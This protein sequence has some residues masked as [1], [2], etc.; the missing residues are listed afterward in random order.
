MEEKRVKVTESGYL[1]DEQDI[2]IKLVNGTEMKGTI[3]VAEY[4]VDRLSEV[5]A[6]KDISFIVIYNCSEC[7]KNEEKLESEE[8]LFINRDHILWAE[9]L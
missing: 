1:V 9:P 8:V 3:N 5:F 7:P 2:R 6:R 4:S